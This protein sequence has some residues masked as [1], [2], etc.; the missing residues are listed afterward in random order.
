MHMGSD[1]K[2]SD[3]VH[4]YAFNIGLGEKVHFSSLRLLADAHDSAPIP[5][6]PPPP[7]TH[8]A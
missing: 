6:Q 5:P 3:G 2:L 4:L 7:P 8:G 1:G